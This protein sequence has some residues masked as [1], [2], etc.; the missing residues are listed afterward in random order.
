MSSYFTAVNG[1]GECGV[2]SPVLFCLYIDDVLLSLSRS[3]VGCCVGSHFAGALAYADHIV[4]I[5]PTARP[6]AMRK[7]L[8]I[9]GNYAIENCTTFN[10]AKSKCLVVLPKNRRVF[11]M[12]LRIMSLSSIIPQSNLLIRLFTWVT[13]SRHIWMTV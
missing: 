5:A 11:F 7:L 9:C 13:C 8:G 6:T 3:G 12:F 2:L 1:F 4:L 10:A